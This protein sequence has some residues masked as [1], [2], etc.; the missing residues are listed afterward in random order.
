MPVKNRARLIL[1]SQGFAQNEGLA[2]WILSRLRSAYRAK[3]STQEKMRLVETLSLGGRRQ[4]MLVE[5]CG[6]RFLVGC[7]TDNVGTIARIAVTRAP[8]DVAD[9]VEGQS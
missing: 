3:A 7:G 4:L 8:G 9:D 6:D 5:C 1:G 2:G